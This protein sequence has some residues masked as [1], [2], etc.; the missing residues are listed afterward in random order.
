MDSH[1]WDC[2][3][4]RAHERQ[5]AVRIN[6]HEARQKR[7]EDA[8]RP[9]FATFLR[10]EPALQQVKRDDGTQAAKALPVHVARQPDED[11]RVG[12][13]DLRRRERQEPGELCVFGGKRADVG[14]DRR[15]AASL[16]KP[17]Q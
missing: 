14:V 4:K 17:S 7:V 13:N 3:G 10:T 16:E 5:R 11:V 8:Q 15:L 1:Q 12:V 9:A 2:V 6:A